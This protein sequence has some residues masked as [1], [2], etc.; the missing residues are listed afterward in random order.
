LFNKMQVPGSRSNH[1]DLYINNEYYG[2]YINIEHIDEEFVKSRFGSR[3]GNL[4]KCLIFSDLAY[5]GE[6]EEDYRIRYEPSQIYESNGYADLI[7]LTKVISNSDPVDLPYNLEPIFN[8]NGFLRY[9]AVEIFTGHWDGYSISVNNYYLYKNNFTNKFEFLPYDVDNTFGIDWYIGNLAQRNIYE[10]WNQNENIPLTSKLF[11]NPIYVDRFSFFI[12]ELISKYAHPDS[13][14]PTIDNIK[15]RIDASAINDKFRTLDY[16]WTIDQYHQSYTHAL[17]DHVKYGLKPYIAER[18][19]S[20]SNQLVLNPIAPII[21]NVY[22]N[23]VSFNT[24]FT[25]QMNITDDDE[26]PTAKIYYQTNEGEFEVK[27]FKV[28]EKNKYAVIIDSISVYGELKYY[29]EASD[30]DNNITREPLLGTYSI[31][32]GERDVELVVNEFMSSNSNTIKDNFGETEDWFE[33]KNNGT[34]SINLQGKFVTDN[35]S[36]PTKF[37]LPDVILEPGQ[38]YIL[39]ADDDVLQGENHTNF[40]LSSDGESICIFNSYENNLMPIYCTDFQKQ[41]PNTSWGINMNSVLIEQNFITPGGENGD[42][43]V[44]FI[45]FSFNMNKWIH[46]GIFQPKTD[47]IDV[48][49]T[50][51]S[52]NGGVQVYDANSDGIYEFTVFGFKAG[53]YIEYKARIN[54]SWSRAEFPELGNEG[55]R[56]YNLKQG[57]NLISHWY[58]DQKLSVPLGIYDNSVAIY[59][60]PVTNK[61]FTIDAAFDINAVVVKSLQGKTLYN[62]EVHEQKSANILVDLPK[63]IYVV[64]IWCKERP[65]FSKIIVY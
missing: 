41:L 28:N 12:N 21:E 33:I 32:G 4:Y 9:L 26:N 51:N 8:V 30:I 11:S 36:E 60:N 59:P 25:I 27:E 23:F 58:N 15:A 46:D 64:Q 24:P 7:N 13:I 47:F 53:D 6:K 10:W 65:Y 48:A 37:M 39:W 54:A 43:D 44:A 5:I 34:K 20:I 3:L 19:N 18:I 22:H 38:F 55:N 56:Q 57:H 52:W 42:S 35:K 61:R 63:G 50:F 40:K 45:T 17:G 62:F 31:K 1:V 29:I 14:Y 2:L 16:G 49:G